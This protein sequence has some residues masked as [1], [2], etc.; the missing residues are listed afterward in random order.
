MQGIRFPAN[1]QLGIG[2]TVGSGFQL[3]S[4]LTFSVVD[5]YKG[6][7]VERL[8]DA[9]CDAHE[10]TTN[11]EQL[12]GHAS[13]G[14]RLAALRAQ[15]E[16][17]ERH[18]PEWRTIEARAQE[19]LA[20][21]V[22]TL[23]EFDELRRYSDALERKWVE[24][25]GETRRLEARGAVTTHRA[26][27]ALLDHYVAGSMRAERQAW[28]IRSL[29]AWQFQLTAGVIPEQPVDWYGLAE[30]SYNFGSLVR[31]HVRDRYL[32]ARVDELHESADELDAK[33]RALDG[34][35][36]ASIDEAR[37]ALEVVDGQVASMTSVRR[38]LEQSEA[39]N[40]IHLHDTLALELMAAEADR[41]FLGAW[42]K[43]LEAL[44]EDAR[45]Q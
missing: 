12:L 3:R 23:V 28:K 32:A 17:L 7:Q 21:Q 34:E 16:Y 38:A 42:S 36:T 30:L 24:V 8:A 22:I 45:A 35:I 5:L 14:A 41:E 4:G 37:R 43:A 40:V 9:E 18:H 19:R 39:A 2:T 25:S 15:G 33:M 20:A 13:D 27:R 31:D 6:V 1:G 29:D 26:F 10:A 11:L 44:S